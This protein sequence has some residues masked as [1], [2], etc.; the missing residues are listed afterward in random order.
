M[1]VSL[2]QDLAWESTT[3]TEGSGVVPGSPSEHRWNQ[4]FQGSVAAPGVSAIVR[5]LDSG[6]SEDSSQGLGS[7]SQRGACAG[8]RDMLAFPGSRWLRAAVRKLGELAASSRRVPASSATRLRGQCC[9]D[10]TGVCRGAAKGIALGRCA[11]PGEGLGVTWHVGAAMLGLMSGLRLEAGVL[12][13]EHE[14]C[15]HGDAS[16]RTSR[17]QGGEEA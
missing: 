14:V 11:T 8:R 13:A 9:W 3:G 16:T 15:T 7:H 10:V 17:P 6:F 2:S 12:L 4:V 5:S 1:T